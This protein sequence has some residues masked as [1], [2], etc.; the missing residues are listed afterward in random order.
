MREKF[1][2]RGSAV[3]N[4]AILEAKS[5]NDLVVKIVDFC[6]GKNIIDVQFGYYTHGSIWGGSGSI[7]SNYTVLILVGI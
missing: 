7:D 3:S 2:F 5:S 1:L 4:V 6:K